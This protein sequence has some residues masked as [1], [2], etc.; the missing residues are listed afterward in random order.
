MGRLFKLIV[1][2]ILLAAVAVVGYAYLGDLEPDRMEVNQ[3]IEL[4]VD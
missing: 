1:F 4:N 3:P 2:L